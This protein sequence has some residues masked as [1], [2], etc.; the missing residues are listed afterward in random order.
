MVCLRRLLLIADDAMARSSS[1][2]AFEGCELRL[3]A[4][5]SPRSAALDVVGQRNPDRVLVDYRLPEMPTPRADRG[6][7]A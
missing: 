2:R 7:T 3:A 1:R 6:E 5:A 4:G